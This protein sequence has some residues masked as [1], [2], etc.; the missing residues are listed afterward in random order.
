M[1]LKGSKTEKN[2][3]IAFA[4]ESEAR[5]KYTFFASQAK[6]DGYVQIQNIFLETAGNEKEHA[7]L[8]Y[9]LA[10]G[11]G[12]TAA[13]LKTAAAGEH[14]EWSDMYAQM[15]KDAREE[16]FNEIADTFAGVAKIEKEHE[17]RYLALL[18]NVEEG[19]VFEKDG[20]V[21]WKCSNCGHIHVGKAA[22]EVCPVCQ[23]ERAYFELQCKNY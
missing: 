20:V 5:N 21:V 22:P 7:E 8:W 6:K 23:H 4:G 9:K 15:E 12:D 18:K 13:N 10:V 14:Y 2:L 19:K 16:G 1:E 3:M 11:I 17:E